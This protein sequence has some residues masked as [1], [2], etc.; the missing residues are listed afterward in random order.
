M[1]RIRVANE[2]S[3]SSCKVLLAQLERA[4]RSSAAGSSPG[5]C[6][7]QNQPIRSA[8]AGTQD[9]QTFRSICPHNL[10][11]GHRGRFAGD[12]FL[13]GR[14]RL[15]RVHW[16]AR[17]LQG[18]VGDCDVAITLFTIHHF[19]VTPLHPS[20]ALPDFPFPRGRFARLM[21]CASAI[22]PR[23]GRLRENLPVPGGYSRRAPR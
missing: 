10:R 20:I 12:I 22:P 19:L 18:I 6:D 17:H 11:G 15:I 16:H 14:N 7:I 9:S 1:S 23:S 5:V 13:R 2:I 8:F 21:G 4:F 3:L